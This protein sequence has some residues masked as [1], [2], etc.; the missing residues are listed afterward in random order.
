MPFRD[1]ERR[2]GLLWSSVA[3]KVGGKST[4]VD[5]FGTKILGSK[6]YL[7]CNEIEKVIGQFNALSGNR[8]LIVFDEVGNWGG[9]YKLNDRMKPLITQTD[10]C[11]ERKGLDAIKTR[12]F[13]NIIFTTNNSWP[14]KREAGDRRYSCQECSGAMVGNREYFDGLIKELEDPQT[15]LS[16][17]AYLSSID[18][19]DWYPQT[20]P[21]TAWGESLKDHSIPPY[22]KMM[23]ALLEN[24]CFHP[25]AETWV[26]TIDNKATY[27]TFLS[28]LNIK[29]DRH[30]DVNVLISNRKSKFGMRAQGR[31]IQ[32]IPTHK[33]WWFPPQGSICKALHSE[34]SWSSTIE[35]VGEWCRYSGYT[36]DEKCHYMA[37]RDSTAGPSTIELSPKG[38]PLCTN[39][40]QCHVREEDEKES[41]E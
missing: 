6:N 21:I 10:T 16:F 18:I 19:S 20:I 29:E 35:W 3:R 32:Q 4:V 9:A 27:D 23:Q 5:F 12:D 31:S 37:K 1:P 7:Y 11:L 24:A 40:S 14:V 41:E 25:S 13:S 38:L 30:M 33:G 2:S 8:L 28:T 15:A 22:I 34:K 36:E 17:H 39:C 26:A